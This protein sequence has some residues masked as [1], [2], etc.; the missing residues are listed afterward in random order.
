VDSVSTVCSPLHPRPQ[1]ARAA[2][3]DLGGAWGFA[4]DDADLGLDERWQER[5]DAFDRQIDR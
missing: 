1:C 2:W 5:S 3:V 4:Y